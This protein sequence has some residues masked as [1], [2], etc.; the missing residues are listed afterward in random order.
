MQV[1]STYRIEATSR[2]C[3]N[4]HIFS[5]GGILDWTKYSIQ[6]RQQ[7]PDKKKNSSVQICI[8]S[9]YNY[10]SIILKTYAYCKRITDVWSVSNRELCEIT[11]YTCHH[12]DYNYDHLKLYHEMKSVNT[13]TQKFAPTLP[14]Q[15][16]LT[17]FVH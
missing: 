11:K 17:N 7:L 6:Q 12:W 15:Q 13:S 9:R 10:C 3:G 4:K 1:M 2:T 14:V 5:A 16:I 8:H